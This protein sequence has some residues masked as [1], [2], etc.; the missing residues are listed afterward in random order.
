MDAMTYG[1]N[2][3]VVEMNR[4]GEFRRDEP[5]QLDTLFPVHRLLP[6]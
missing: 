5:D 3:V 2:I 4:D 1:E 6:S